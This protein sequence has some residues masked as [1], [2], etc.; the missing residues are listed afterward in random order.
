MLANMSQSKDTGD[1][2]GVCIQSLLQYINTTSQHDNAN[3]YVL[4]LFSD[5]VKPNVRNIIFNSLFHTQTFHLIGGKPHVSGEIKENWECNK[6]HFMIFVVAFLKFFALF[7]LPSHMELFIL[8][9]PSMQNVFTFFNF[10]AN[11]FLYKVYVEENLLQTFSFVPHIH[12]RE[13]R[14]YCESFLIKV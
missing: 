3:K 6:N 9:L 1:D 8:L 13:W 5:N 7:L 12:T 2:Y 10:Q 14:T 4:H 11:F